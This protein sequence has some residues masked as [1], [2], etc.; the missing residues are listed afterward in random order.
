MDYDFDRALVHRRLRLT[1]LLSL[2][3]IYDWTFTFNALFGRFIAYDWRTRI[4]QR[5]DV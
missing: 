2:A 3:I 1:L 5:Y 4:A